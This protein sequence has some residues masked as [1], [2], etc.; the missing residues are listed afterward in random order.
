M[1]TASEREAFID[2]VCAVRQVIAAEAKATAALQKMEIML[3]VL[4]STVSLLI[5]RTDDDVVKTLVDLK[6]Q[7]LA[8][9]VV[10]TF[11]VKKAI[12]DLTGDIGN[13]PFIAVG[14]NSRC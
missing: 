6:Q 4:V 8:N 7:V 14:L 9:K 3:L 10:T 2:V 13:H 12:I 1:T 5:G 11:K